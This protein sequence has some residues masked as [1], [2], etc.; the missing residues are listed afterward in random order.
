M[1]SFLFML[2][3][4]GPSDLSLRIISSVWSLLSP[5]FWAIALIW[6]W[7]L[8]PSCVIASVWSLLSPLSWAIAS[9]WSLLSPLSWA[10][11]RYYYILPVWLQLRSDHYCHTF[12][13]YI[14]SFL[15]YSFSPIVTITLFLSYRFFSSISYWF[16]RLNNGII[17][18]LHLLLLLFDKS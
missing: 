17:K 6:S 1:P 5:L 18:G 2:P 16:G 13:S 14:T 4:L 8:H 3:T 12:L 10:I 11:D 7:L 15:S 9:I